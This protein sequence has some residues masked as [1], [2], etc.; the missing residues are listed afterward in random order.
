MIA[1]SLLPLLL[2]VCHAAAVPNLARAESTATSASSSSSSSSS[3]AAPTPWLSVVDSDGTIST[4]TPVVSTDASGQPTTI[5]A[6][7]TDARPANAAPSDVRSPDNNAPDVFARCDSSKYELAETGNKQPY[8][9]F[10]APRNG[11]NWW[12]SGNY[13][14]TWNPGHYPINSTVRIVLNYQTPG[15]G[16]RVADSVCIPPPPES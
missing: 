10:C 11:T 13:Y 1:A 16:G 5:D 7:P 12:F 6:K 4:V 14:V 9:P 3:S 2:L 8:V 15:D